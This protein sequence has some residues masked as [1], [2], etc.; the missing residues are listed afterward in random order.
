M[1]V[2]T[3]HFSG[4]WVSMKVKGGEPPAQE[5]QAADIKAAPVTDEAEEAQRMKGLTTNQ[6]LHEEDSDGAHISVHCLLA[7]G[8]GWGAARSPQ[9]QGWWQVGVQGERLGMEGAWVVWGLEMTQ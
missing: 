7:A 5:G 6:E 2:P 3:P 4:H 1:R 9:E 8:V